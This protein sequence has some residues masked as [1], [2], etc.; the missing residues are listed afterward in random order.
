MNV[1]PISISWRSP[2][3]TQSAVPH[4]EMNTQL[5]LFVSRGHPLKHSLNKLKSSKLSTESKTETLELSS[6]HIHY[7]PLLPFFEWPYLSISVLTCTYLS[8]PWLSCTLTNRPDTVWGF[9]FIGFSLKRRQMT[10]TNRTTKPKGKLKNNSHK[11]T[12]SPTETGSN[13]QGLELAHWH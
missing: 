11:Q 7:G 13:K 9:T 4:K 2:V 3:C 10:W 12:E 5:S 8:L 1:G 6:R